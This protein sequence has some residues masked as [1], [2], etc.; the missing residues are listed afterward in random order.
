MNVYA[1]IYEICR[2]KG[3]SV[4]EL[5]RQCAFPQGSIRRWVSVSPGIDKVAKVA[6]VLGCTI[7]ELCGRVP[8]DNPRDESL[9]TGFIEEM[10]S[11]SDF[12]DDEK[13]IIRKFRMLSDSDKYSVLM[14]IMRLE[15]EK[16]V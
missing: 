11:K 10:R 12:S 13:T 2:Q 9:L 6:D 1:V 5:E 7:D 14:T 15:P 3:I 16:E 4:R 8:Q